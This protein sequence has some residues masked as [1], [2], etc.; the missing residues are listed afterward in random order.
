[1]SNPQINPLARSLVNFAR[2]TY[3]SLDELPG[4]Q[5]PCSVV[6][7]NNG[8]VTVKFELTSPINFG[9]MQVPQAISRYAR[10]PT[11][12]GDKGFVVAADVY[13]GG[14]TGLGGGTATYGRVESNLTALVFVPVS[15]TSY[16]IVD[17]NAY[18]ITGPNG[19][20]IQD[21]SAA[22]VIKITPTGILLTQGSASI[23][24]TGGQILISG[25]LIINGN[26]FTAHAHTGVSTG[27]G[28]SGG[29]A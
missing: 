3:A 22:S 26:P 24:I 8:M 9:T 4:R 20:V 29:V 18:W 12:V 7:V 15:T 13:L 19:A 27:S 2:G 17:P 21:D 11:Q 1:M 23:S 10:P 5:L 25:T 28:I 16:P 14:V 6:A